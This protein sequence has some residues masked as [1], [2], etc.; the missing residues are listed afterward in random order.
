MNTTVGDRRSTHLFNPNKDVIKYIGDVSFISFT[1]SDKL[2]SIAKVYQFCAPF[3]F[4]DDTFVMEVQF[5]VQVIPNYDGLIVVLYKEEGQFTVDA[6]R[7]DINTLNKYIHW[8]VDTYEE[9]NYLLENLRNLCAC[10]M[11]FSNAD[12]K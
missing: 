1:K 8:V 7:A 10:T 4:A 2:P 5:Y 11:A 3:L 12:V 6:I 9:E